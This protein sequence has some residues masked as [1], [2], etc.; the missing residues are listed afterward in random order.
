MVSKCSIGNQVYKPE[1]SHS[2]TAYQSVNY[3]AGAELI[4]KCLCCRREGL[5]PVRTY[6]CPWS[7]SSGWRPKELSCCCRGAWITVSV[8][9]KEKSRN[10][11]LGGSFGVQRGP[12]LA[13]AHNSTC[14][15]FCVWSVYTKYLG[16]LTVHN[17][18][19]VFCKLTSAY[20]FP[21]RLPLRSS[22]NCIYFIFILYLLN[23]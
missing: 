10:L 12:I 5:G 22:F 21:F 19:L 14:V 18:Y 17:G 4:A 6:R 11:V 16:F 7:A 15:A 23:A 9:G 13:L 3:R 8:S 2:Q 20:F 1:C